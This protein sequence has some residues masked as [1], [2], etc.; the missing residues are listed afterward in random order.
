[1]KFRCASTALFLVLALS[2][3][4]L[5]KT[6]PERAAPSY[7]GTEAELLLDPD[8]GFLS[9]V[10]TLAEFAQ[11]GVSEVSAS[12]YDITG[13][14][15][16]TM[17]LIDASLTIFETTTSVTDGLDVFLVGEL[18]R[19]SDFGGNSWEISFSVTGGEAASLYGPSTL[20]LFNNILTNTDPF[21]NEIFGTADVTISGVVSPQVVPLPASFALLLVALSGL[22]GMARRS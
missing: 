8:F 15:D 17:G 21:T 14:Y 13:V 5:A 7:S 1:M 20:V 16:N 3:S 9:I 4:A 6:L 22:V 2:N 19:A 18:D 11:S 12:H 10:G